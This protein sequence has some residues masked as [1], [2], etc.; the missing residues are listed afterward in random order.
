M[1][2]KPDP[3]FDPAQGKDKPSDAAEGKPSDAAKDSP[4]DHAEQYFE[5][6]TVR[7]D[8][9]MAAKIAGLRPPP[10]ETPD[11]VEIRDAAAVVPTLDRVVDRESAPPTPPSASTSSTVADAFT[12]LLALE[13]GEPGANPVRLVSG[14]GEARITDALL[15]ELTRRII[16]R[17][18][19]NAAREVVVEV[20]SE[21]AERLVSAEIERIRKKH[22]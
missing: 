18:G 22:V 19:P 3:P 5:S 1:A 11:S 12:A 17:L 14:D 16:E 10:V 4:P 7:L 9:A 21:V 15:E 8:A 6:M 2:E 20:V 13:D